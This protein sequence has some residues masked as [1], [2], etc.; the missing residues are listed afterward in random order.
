MFHSTSLDEACQ[1]PAFQ[2]IFWQSCLEKP[3][4]WGQKYEQMNLI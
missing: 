2:N 4:K 3:D 1:F